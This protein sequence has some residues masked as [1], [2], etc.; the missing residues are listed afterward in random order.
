MRTVALFQL[1]FGLVTLIGG[2]LDYVASDSLVS[3]IA[4]PIA[5]LVLISAGL[6]IQKG[7]RPGLYVA[8]I[9]ALTLIG[10]FGR[11]YFYDESTFFPAGLIAIMG[12]I[13]LLLVVLIM[14]QPRERTRDF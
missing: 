3:L 8:L 2:I 11:S 7:W 1:L 4:G 9:M 10:Y 5:G 14:L 6:R 13:S 12:I